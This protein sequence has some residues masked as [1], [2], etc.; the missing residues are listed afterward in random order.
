MSTDAPIERK[1]LIRKSGEIRNLK[2][3]LRYFLK[4]IANKSIIAINPKII[5]P[6]L[7]SF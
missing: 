7:V 3:D 2:K 1:K 4:M 6:M 5:I